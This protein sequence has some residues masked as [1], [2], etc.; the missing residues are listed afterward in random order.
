MIKL[1][2]CLPAQF[3]PD[4]GGRTKT[5]NRA[6]LCCIGRGGQGFG[7][8]GGYPA[9]AINQ[10]LSAANPQKRPV[11]FIEE[12]WCVANLFQGGQR[13]ETKNAEGAGTRLDAFQS[14]DSFGFYATRVGHASFAEAVR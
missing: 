11:D 12:I 3:P 9:Q 2:A 1:K 13:P 4:T 5:A 10:W 8:P 14:L 6:L 7:R